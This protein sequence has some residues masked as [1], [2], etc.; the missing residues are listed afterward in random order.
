MRKIIKIINDKIHN[1]IEKWYNIKFHFNMWF[2]CIDASGVRVCSACPSIDI[3]DEACVLLGKNIWI[4][5]FRFTSWFCKTKIVV[6]KG[7]KLSIGNNSGLNGVLLCCHDCITI[8]EHVNIGG[9]T[10]IYDTDFH[11][12][13]WQDRRAGCGI[14]KTAPVVIENDVFIG[15]GCIIGKGRR[16][17]ARS[18]IAA[19]SVVTKDIP[20]DCIAG[21]NPCKV[22]RYLGDVC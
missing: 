7:A 21:G 9:G 3:H 11:P 14:T 5:N 1:Q 20:A 10:R 17:G 18:V 2:H 8:G 15:T 12:I 13:D 19:G 6:G 16:I 4:N 22:I